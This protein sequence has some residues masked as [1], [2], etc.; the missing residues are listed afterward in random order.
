MSRYPFGDEFVLG[1][2]LYIYIYPLGPALYIYRYIYIYI[3]PGLSTI[4]IY[5][6]GPALY[7]YIYIYT[8]P[9]LKKSSFGGSPK[10]ENLELALEGKF[11]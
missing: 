1:P 2:A 10:N 11:N 3:S 9:G 8:S 5:P 6:L 7:I 4:Y